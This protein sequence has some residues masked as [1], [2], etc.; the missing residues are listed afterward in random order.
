MTV[1]NSREFSTNPIYYLNLARRQEIA[2]KRG[3][4]IFQIMPKPQSVDLSPEKEKEFFFT[5]SKK[6]MSK[7]FEKYL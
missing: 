4:V 5:G 6:S 3:N 7:H 2:V 1:V